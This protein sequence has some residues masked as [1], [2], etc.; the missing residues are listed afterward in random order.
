MKNT[1]LSVGIFKRHKVF[2]VIFSFL[3]L[4]V[5]AG[6]VAIVQQ[7][8]TIRSKAAESCKVNC[9]A[10]KTTKLCDQNGKT[11]NGIQVCKWYKDYGCLAL[12]KYKGNGASNNGYTYTYTCPNTAATCNQVGESCCNIVTISRIIASRS[13]VFGI[14][15][16]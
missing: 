8:Q 2:T 5:L 13:G 6:S 12:Q 10:I 3:F 14:F 4:A 7:Q 11:E 1:D 16:M 15:F 9:F